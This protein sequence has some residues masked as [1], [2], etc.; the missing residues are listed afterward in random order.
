MKKSIISGFLLL[1]L[2]FTL[3][4]FINNAKI[5]RANY[6]LIERSINNI[7][8][9]NKEFDYY[10]RTSLVYDNF[11]IIQ[12]KIKFFKNEINNI[13][14]N[15]LLK[16]IK[17]DKF[18]NIIKDLDKL[19]R[20][21]FETI[22][23]AK[24]HKAVLNNSFRIIQRLNNQGV[25]QSLNNLYTIIMTVDKNNSLN[26][27]NEIKKIEKIEKS[28]VDKYD[29]FFLK[30][31][32]VIL[33]HQMKFLNLEK[34]S[35]KLD[36]NKLLIE[37][38]TLYKEHS[39]KSNDKADL[40]IN[41]LFFFLLIGIVLYFIKEYRLN[42]TNKMLIRFKE[43][44]HNSNNIIVIT[45]KDENIKYVN[46]AF[47]KSTGYTL[48]DVVGKKTNILQSGQKS[49]KFYQ[50]LKKTIHSGKKWSGEFINKNKEGN[51][52][53]EKA[54]ITPVFD[55]KGKIIEFI[56]IK[57]DITKETIIE[58]QL[59]EQEKLLV[60]QSKLAAM[61]EMIANIAHQWRQPLSVISTG[62]TGMQLQ[63]EYGILSDEEF[64][65]TCKFIDKNVQYLSNTIDDFRNF[66]KGD[67]NKTIFDLEKQIHSVLHLV[68]G[69]TKR[70]DIT[71]VLD[72]QNDIKINGYENELI[73]CF[74][75]I[76]NNA[77]DALI[78]NDIEKKY[79]FISA[80]T[81]KDHIEINIK[82]NA[83]GIPTEILPKIFEQYFTTKHKSV[84]TGLG[85]NMTYNIIVERMNGTIQ[86]IN[87]E[88]T[89]NDKNY[90]GANFIIKL[91][92]S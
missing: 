31:S 45:D 32:K 39:Q 50:N 89:Y 58:Q 70:H 63:K 23:K 66:I 47:I 90:K 79:I 4:Y 36:I 35:I 69:S 62:V 12:Y 78:Q 57:L 59:K 77:K 67:N 11:D 51:L 83:N 74:M 26:I 61:G 24:S 53:Y 86:A 81:K 54:S 6:S 3:A 49:K 44:L 29:K 71:I 27:K 17:D 87:E 40:A 52:I 34:K 7:S 41:A 18:Q 56:A 42:K 64:N 25:S 48:S 91:P 75:N 2:L 82:D 30:H 55:D 60:D 84:G 9:L 73:Q 92:L 16:K 76:Y 1:T 5:Q 10:Y 14:N 85:L 88:Y 72:L 21:K 15:Q 37:F 38:N 28:Y 33:E 43:T 19:I 22:N 20:L 80:N 46:D 65:K 13:K 68:E 8:I